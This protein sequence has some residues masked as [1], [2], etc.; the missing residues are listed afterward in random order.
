MQSLVD[1]YNGL[2]IDL[3]FY[4]SNQIVTVKFESTK[5]YRVIDEGYRL[6]Q[7]QHLPLPMAETMYVVS[8]SDMVEE[9]VD[10]SCGTVESASVIHYLVVTD[11]D[12]IDVIVGADVEP[13]LSYK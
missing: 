3:I 6:R 5:V 7:L 4:D 12:C 10:E 2:E 11:N 8:N 13:Q 1:G 9:L